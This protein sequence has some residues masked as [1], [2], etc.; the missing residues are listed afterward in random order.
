ME[1]AVKRFGMQKLC[2]IC[3][4]SSI[5]VGGFLWNFTNFLYC[6]ILGSNPKKIF[7]L[8]VYEFLFQKF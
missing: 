7:N 3:L 5:K 4:K 8:W 1:I 2:K 6:E